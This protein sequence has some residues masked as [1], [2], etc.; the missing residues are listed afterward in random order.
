MEPVSKFFAK[1]PSARIDEEHSIPDE[2]M[3]GLRELGLFGL[4]IPEEYGGLVRYPIRWVVSVYRHKS[5]ANSNFRDFP[6]PVTRASLKR[7]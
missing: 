7:S 1:V 4:Q 6:I 5:C 3:A 2:V